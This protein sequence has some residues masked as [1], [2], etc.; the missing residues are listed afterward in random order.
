MAYFNF[1]EISWNLTAFSCILIQFCLPCIFK[2]T[3]GPIMITAHRFHLFPCFG[4]IFIK[5]C[6]LATTSQSDNLT[7]RDR[8]LLWLHSN[9]ETIG[10]CGV[11]LCEFSG[12]I[13]HGICAKSKWSGSCANAWCNI[14]SSSSFWSSNHWLQ[15]QI[16]KSLT[17]TALHN[18]VFTCVSNH[19]NQKWAL[20]SNNR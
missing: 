18:V 2:E 16:I 11:K 15:H 7:E 9:V 13:L 8:S 3:D 19:Q 12:A 6:I 4:C 1:I 5:N 14:D 20:Y 17:Y 10:S